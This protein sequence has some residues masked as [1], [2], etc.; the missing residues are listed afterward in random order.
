[1]LTEKQLAPKMVG[2]LSLFKEFYDGHEVAREDLPALQTAIITKLR[3]RR[4][5][6]ETAD[7]PSM[8]NHFNLLTSYGL[9]DL[10]IDKTITLSLRHQSKVRCQLDLNYIKDYVRAKGLDYG[11]LLNFN[12]THKDEGIYIVK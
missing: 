4:W 9:P 3:A 2:L 10:I 6:V 5:L 12:V 8:A 11:V 1:M 7:C